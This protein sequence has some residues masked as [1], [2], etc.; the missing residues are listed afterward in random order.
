MKTMKRVLAMVLT[1]AA[2]LVLAAC[3]QTN[4]PVA[5]DNSGTGEQ[6]E[7][8]CAFL[9]TRSHHRYELVLQRVSRL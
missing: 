3:G 2:L 4:E 6:T 7:F 1:V 9:S 5:D 8:K